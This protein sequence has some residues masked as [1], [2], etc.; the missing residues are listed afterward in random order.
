MSPFPTLPSANFSIRRCFS[1]TGFGIAFAAMQAGRRAGR[2]EKKEAAGPGEQPRDAVRVR[3]DR[4]SPGHRADEQG[5]A[6]GNGDVT[7]ADGVAPTPDGRRTARLPPAGVRASRRGRHKEIPHPAGC[8]MEGIRPLRSRPPE[9][10]WACLK[11]QS[12]EWFWSRTDSAAASKGPDTLVL[13]TSHPPAR[14]GCRENQSAIS[15]SSM[16]VPH[17]P[18]LLSRQRLQG[19]P[20]P[21]RSPATRPMPRSM[22]QRTAFSR[23]A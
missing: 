4:D 5:G 8:G 17:L 14:K 15:V 23:T 2:T 3:P 6:E 10:G 19:E 9:G 13:Q 1:D 11:R 21:V 20:P 18:G 22:Q 16:T 12:V 7:V